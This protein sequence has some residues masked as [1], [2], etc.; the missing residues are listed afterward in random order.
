M[1]FWEFNSSSVSP[2]AW[3]SLLHQVRLKPEWSNVPGTSDRHL[4]QLSCCWC[5]LNLLR[6]SLSPGGAG[7]GVIASATR[8]HRDRC[9]VQPELAACHRLYKHTQR[10]TQCYSTVCAGL[11]RVMTLCKQ[12]CSF[13]PAKIF[14]KQKKLSF[15]THA[16]DMLNQSPP[17]SEVLP[18]LPSSPSA[19]SL[20]LRELSDR[21]TTESQK[22]VSQTPQ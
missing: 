5:H 9:P 4:Q 19:V 2:A 8:K 22:R 1:R 13:R 21:L 16:E 15:L 17:L 18:P 12:T 3:F 10:N 14:L 11:C 7:S 6:Y 20:L